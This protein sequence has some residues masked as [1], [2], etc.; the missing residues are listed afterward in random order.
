MINYKLKAK[1]EN[2][3][4]VFLLFLQKKE[5]LLFSFIKK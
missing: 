4:Y 2:I 1:I 3:L 5:V